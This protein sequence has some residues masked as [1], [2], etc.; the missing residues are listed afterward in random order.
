MAK[1]Y[2]LEF[3]H[4]EKEV[5]NGFLVSGEYRKTAQHLAVMLVRCY[6]F[7]IMFW[8]RFQSSL[9]PFFFASPNKSLAFFTSCDCWTKE[10]MFC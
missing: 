6:V 1:E 2:L 7:K 5:R 9:Q 4:N 10:A 8:F 3:A